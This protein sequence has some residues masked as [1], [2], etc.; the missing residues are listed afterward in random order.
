[1][2]TDLSRYVVE[3]RQSSLLSTWQWAAREGDAVVAR[4]LGLFSTRE[5]AERD[6]VRRL[7]QLAGSETLSGEELRARV[8]EREG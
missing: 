7:E 4:G 2:S 8:R 3:I 1:M 6:A 5:A